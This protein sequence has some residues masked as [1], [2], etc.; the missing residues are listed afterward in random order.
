MKRLLLLMVAAVGLATTGY[1]QITTFPYV[2]DFEGFAQCGGSCTSVC[3]LQDNWVNAATATRDF[4]SD[5]GGTG[6]NPTGP[7]TGGT[8]TS[9]YLYTEASSPCNPISSWH[10]LSPTIDLTGTNDIQF[11]FM[12]HMFGQSMGTAHVDVSDDGGTTWNLDVVPAWTDNQ[13]LWQQQVV[14][15]GTFNGIVTV[16][17]RYEDPPG[18]YGDFAIDDVSI[19]DL[20]ANDAGIAAFIDPAI[21]TCNFNDTV[22]VELVNYGTDTLVSANID[23][24]WNAASQPTYAWSGSIAPGQSMPVFLGTAAYAAG[25]NLFAW[26]SMPNGM[27]EVPSGAG[28]DTTIILGLDAGL[29][30]LYTI[31]GTTPDYPDFT[32]AV[33]A[34]T[35]FGICGP[36]VFDV[37]DGVYNEQIVFSEIVGTDATNTITFRSENG[38]ASLV[39]LSYAA[40]LSTEN[41]VINMGGGDYFTFEDLT[42][43][44]TG[45]TYGRVLDYTDGSDWNTVSRC[46]LLNVSNTTSTNRCVVWSASGSNAN[47]NSFLNNVIEGGSYGVYWYG[48]GTSSLSENV[49]F[50]GNEFLNNYYYGTRLYY[51]LNPVFTNNITYGETTY[52]GTRYAHYFYYC[53]GAMEVTNNAVYGGFTS[54]WYYGLYFGQCDGFAANRS[55]VSNNMVA[56]GKPA[57]TSS[58]YGIYLNNSGYMDI[59]SNNVLVTEG[60]ASSRAFYATSGGAIFVNNNNFANLT[61]G[62][63]VYVQSAFSIDEMDYNNI[64]SPLGNIGY[65]AVNQATLTDWQT[66][67]GYDANSVSVDPMYYSNMD[68]HVCNDT[69]KGAGLA[70]TNV[71]T[72][73]DGQPRSA[74]PDLGADEFTALATSFLGADA[75][76][77]TGDSIILWAGAPADNVTWSTGDT[78]NMIVVN[79]PGSYS[80]TVV[81]ACGIGVDTVVVSTSALAYTNFLE[82]DTL[83]FCAGDT[84]TLSSTMAADTYTWTGGATT[85]TLSVTTGGTYQLDITDAC[86]TGSESVLVTEQ[87]APTASFTWVNVFATGV[88]TNTT[89]AAANPTYSWDFGDGNTSTDSDPTHVYSAIG[90][91]YVELTVTNDCGTSVFGDSITLSEVGLNEL[92]TAGDVSVFPNPST[93]EFTISMDVLSSTNITI[94]VENVLG[95]IVYESNPGVIEGTHTEEVSLGAAQSGMYFVR[96]LAGDQQLVKKI[97]IE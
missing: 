33:A 31:G 56:A 16:R 49:V 29:S 96:V 28:N 59:E 61:P 45:I 23:W 39:S 17:I 4:A 54:G 69:L 67:S 94:Q 92:F 11:T 58:M 75:G 36:T 38:D 8:A 7:Q 79:T 52:T 89:S 84:V 15:L 86:G 35:L 93:G 10:L 18:F 88:F 85:P 25:D 13:D 21:P 6:S 57:T 73:F 80:V 30:G 1:S 63:G 76:L 26:S 14:S 48:S 19:Y 24:I 50:D 47:N 62:Y 90:T 60:G 51:C 20:L 83:E 70:S 82:A 71:T 40:T 46:H 27:A 37:R 77:C 91:Y 68:L 32:T 97:I 64:Y 55:Q 3:A 41:Y 78:T 5:V 72:D 22:T 2:Q 9:R 44:N 87:T 34:L 12:Y 43:E 65:F 53:D 81:G 74:T 95:A 66:A 42:I